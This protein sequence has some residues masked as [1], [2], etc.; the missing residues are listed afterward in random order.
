MLENK[1]A[2]ELLKLYTL[3]E[4]SEDQED[5]EKFTDACKELLISEDE[6]RQFVGKN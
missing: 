6:I 2:K 1:E 5:Y 3:Q 4:Q